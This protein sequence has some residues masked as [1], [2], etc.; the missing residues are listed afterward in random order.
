MTEQLDVTTCYCHYNGWSA[1]HRD[2]RSMCEL[3]YDKECKPQEYQCHH[4]V[5]WLEKQ[6]E[7][8]SNKL[9]ELEKVAIT[10]YE[11]WMYYIANGVNNCSDKSV[12]QLLVDLSVIVRLMF[13]GLQIHDN[14]L[15]YFT[16]ESNIYKKKKQNITNL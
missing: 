13:D 5:Q 7:I 4:Y 8:K 2:T 11:M 6:L 1:L 15:H 12:Q 9:N 10:S 14:T 3:G 16:N